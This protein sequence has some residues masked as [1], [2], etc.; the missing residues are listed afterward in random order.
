EKAKVQAESKAKTA[1]AEK[2]Q[3]HAEEVLPE[4]EAHEEGK[5][6]A[7]EDGVEHHAPVELAKESEGVDLEKL[8]EHL[9]TLVTVDQLDTFRHKAQHLAS[10]VFYEEVRIERSRCCCTPKRALGAL[11]VAVV[12][13]AALA[14]R[15]VSQSL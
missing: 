9:Q 4:V 7:L 14:L 6:M 3:L 15:L 11:A 5:K 10:G 13:A 1:K 2:E 8:A 12:G